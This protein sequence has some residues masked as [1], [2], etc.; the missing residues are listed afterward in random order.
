MVFLV[1]LPGGNAIFWPDWVVL[2]AAVG[3][4]N[5]FVLIPFLVF[6]SLYA[7]N[8]RTEYSRTGAPFALGWGAPSWSYSRALPGGLRGF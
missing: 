2:L 7:Y 4:I 3:L 1:A 8:T 6:G 5:V